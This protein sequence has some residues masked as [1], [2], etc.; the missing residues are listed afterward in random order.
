MTRAVSGLLSASIHSASS[1]RPLLA[2][3]IFGAGA[4]VSTDRKPRGTFSPGLFTSPRSNT[5]DS[6]M[7][8]NSGGRAKRPSRS[9]KREAIA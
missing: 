3:G 6:L 7:T 1:R 2:A 8:R 4:C 5:G 9:R